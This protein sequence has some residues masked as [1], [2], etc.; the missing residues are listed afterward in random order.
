M[1][2]EEKFLGYGKQESI[3]ESWEVLAY[4]EGW[5]DSWEE[6]GTGR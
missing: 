5:R 2:K 6:E 3:A 4:V 1:L